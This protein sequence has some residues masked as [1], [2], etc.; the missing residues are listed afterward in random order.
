[1]K[2]VTPLEV[3]KGKRLKRI[4]Q[5]WPTNVG[6]ASFGSGTYWKKV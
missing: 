5:K 4:I 2:R 1:M 6:A 3:E